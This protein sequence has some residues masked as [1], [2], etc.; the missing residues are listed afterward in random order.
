M[1][2]RGLP[3]ALNQQ[4]SHSSVPLIISGKHRDAINEWHL[5]SREE[6]GKLCLSYFWSA[7]TRLPKHREISTCTG[8]IAEH[9]W[10]DTCF[11]DSC[12]GSF[13][14]SLKAADKTLEPIVLP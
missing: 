14:A 13:K 6:V 2:S 12:E 8:R 1:V 10:R 11:P 4:D 5:G 3:S 9:G 7:R